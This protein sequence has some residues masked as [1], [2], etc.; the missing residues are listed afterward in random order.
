MWPKILLELLPH[1]T[2]VLPL[3]DRYFSSRGDQ[4]KAH[5][6]ALTSLGDEVRGGLGRVDE[7]HAGL[8]D[9]LKAQGEQI[10]EVGVEATRARM[11]VESVEARVAKLE[12]TAGIAMRAAVAAVVLLFLV[13]SMV[14]I[15]LLE[16][17]RR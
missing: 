11:A 6:A 1:F 7:V 12:R 4:D 10:A 3:A 9:A 15:V 13:G 5:A 8:K 14:A 16:L 2:R 17:R